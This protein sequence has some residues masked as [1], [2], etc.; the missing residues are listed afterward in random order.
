ML[1]RERKGQANVDQLKERLVKACLYVVVIVV[2]TWCKKN[3]FL[4]VGDGYFIDMLSELK[5]FC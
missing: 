3:S 4:R 1:L 2:T 5:F